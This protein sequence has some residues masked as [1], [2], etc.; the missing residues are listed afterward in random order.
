MDDLTTMFLE[1]GWVH[2]TK[3]VR[4]HHKLFVRTQLFIMCELE[5]LGSRKPLQQFTTE[6]NMSLTEH[7]KF[8]RIFVERL[9][10]TRV[11]MLT[12]LP[13]LISSNQSSRSI[14]INIYLVLEDLLM[15]SMSNGVNVL[16]EITT[17]AKGRRLFHP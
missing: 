5:H 13:L 3:H 9:Y 12:I 17:S 8:L 6:T 10:E 7:T 1:R 15:L 11:S 14:T 4:D 16:Q 2:P